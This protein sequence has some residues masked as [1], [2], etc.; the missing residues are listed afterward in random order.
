MP[1]LRKATLMLAIIAIFACIIWYMN[2]KEKE[3][4]QIAT[5]TFNQYAP[6]LSQYRSEIHEENDSLRVVFL[7]KDDVGEKGSPG[8]VPAF[9]VELSAKTLE[10]KRSNFVR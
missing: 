5:E 10:V 4:L 2:P 7:P 9:E 6:D 1:K 3:A 8:P